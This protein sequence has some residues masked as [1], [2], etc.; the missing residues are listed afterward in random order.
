V[1]VCSTQE[2]GCE[3]KKRERHRNADDRE[4]SGSSRSS[5]VFVVV[6]SC[7]VHRRPNQHPTCWV[8]THPPSLPPFF[9][10]CA[11]ARLLAHQRTCVRAFCTASAQVFRTFFSLSLLFFFVFPCFA[12]FFLVSLQLCS[13]TTVHF[14]VVLE[15]LAVSLPPPFHSNT[16]THRW[17]CSQRVMDACT[18]RKSYV[19]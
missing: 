18:R 9:E 12:F 1:C 15:Y 3:K 8:S 4:G 19:P 5:L 7:S 10:C 6:V 2:G 14:C 11:E 17:Q 13:F 16:H